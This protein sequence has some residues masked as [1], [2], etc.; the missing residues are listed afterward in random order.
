M[1]IILEWQVNDIFFFQLQNYAHFWT[2][3]T[4]KDVNSKERIL[5]P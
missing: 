3:C 4:V 5:T 2:A 1:I